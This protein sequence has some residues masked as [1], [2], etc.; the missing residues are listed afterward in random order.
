[1]KIGAFNVNEP[2]PELREPYA[3]AILRPW[4]LDVGNVGD[5]TLSSLESHFNAV[6]LAEIARPGRFF[7]FT[8]YRPSLSFKEGRRD[9]QIPNTTISYARTDTEHDFLFLH[10]LEPHSLAEVYNDS[11][12][13]VLKKFG[14]K[15]YC[16]LCARYDMVPHTKPILVSGIASNPGLQEELESAGVVPTEYQGAVANPFLI[17]QQAAEKGIESLYLIAHLPHYLIMENDYRGQKRLIEVLGSLYGFPL[18]LADAD[19]AKEQNEQVSMIAENMIREEPKYG[20]ILKQLEAYYDSQAHERKENIQL[21]PE[22]EDFLQDLN[23]R[24]RQE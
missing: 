2:V 8:R 17:W 16:L 24:F 5:L 19:K 9:V 21:S 1:M 3:F 11:V 12:L 10:L 7:D 22:V 18:S 13:R 20:L 4:G 15:R 14:V 6:G 23:Q